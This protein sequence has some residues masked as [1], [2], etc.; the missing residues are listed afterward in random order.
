MALEGYK[1]LK[2]SEALAEMPE[3]SA[4]GEWEKLSPHNRGLWCA[5]H[6]GAS[7]I[8]DI[9]DAIVI[10]HAPLQCQSSR[11]KFFA[12][13]GGDRAPFSLAHTPCTNVGNQ[14]VI[15]G[16]EEKL[17]EAIL[18]VDKDY[19]PGLIGVVA[20][21]ATSMNM[22]DIPGIVERLR[23]QVNAKLYWVRLPGFAST[24][25]SE[26]GDNFLPKMV[27]EL[28]EKPDKIIK[29]AV[30]IVG[31]RFHDFA[32][33]SPDMPVARRRFPKKWGSNQQ[34]LARTIEALGLKLHR[35]IIGGN[36]DYFKT[37]PQ[38]AVNTMTCSDW[39]W[40]IAETMEE[41]FGTP[42][43]PE[44]RA[45]GVEASSSWIMDLAKFMKIEDKGQKLIKEEYS[46]IKDVWEKAKK[47]A[48]GKIALVEGS[49]SSGYQALRPLA[50]ARFAQDLGMKP[51][52]FNIHPA[53]M[54]TKER[55]CR[56]F[57]SKGC[58]PPFL[59]G[60]YPY[61][62]TLRDELI[63]EDIGAS[64]EDCVYFTHD[65][66]VNASA[67]E[68]DASTCATFPI[69]GRPHRRVVGIARDDGFE[70]AGVMAQEVIEAIKATRGSKTCLRPTLYSR[71]MGKKQFDFQ[72]NAGCFRS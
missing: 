27:R 32:Q 71:V 58:D 5:W 31:S 70:A 63:L 66:F 18:Q 68:F 4:Y 9:E 15:L 2:L 30:N 41:E 49:R 19:K 38:A 29:D 35:V 44:G 57:I 47:M 42:W 7:F 37:A 23:P 21:C 16:G 12:S 51:Y 25:S 8:Q 65:L 14:E 48:S 53:N 13:L 43:L 1:W 39:G 50:V 17:E 10:S 62:K 28:M 52:M 6:Y 67:P 34:T 59:L 69:G 46:K 54:K 26:M 55:V 64:P 33:D 20:G 60:P 11:N 22:D 61:Q 40:P 24:W 72:I 36:Y 45:I 3:I 56:H